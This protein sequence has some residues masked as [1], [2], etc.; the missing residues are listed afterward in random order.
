MQISTPQNVPKVAY[1][2]S[3]TIFTCHPCKKEYMCDKLPCYTYNPSQGRNIWALKKCWFTDII[4]TS[5]F[6]KMASSAK[7]LKHC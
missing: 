3:F 2:P 6:H 7:P 1:F 5:H 4:M